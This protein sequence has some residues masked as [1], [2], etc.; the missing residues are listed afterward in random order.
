MC[1]NTSQTFL[2]TWLNTIV[3][4]SVDANRIFPKIDHSAIDARI[5]LEQSILR[6][7]GAPNNDWILKPRTV[8]C[9][10]FLC[11]AFPQC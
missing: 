8:Y 11:D 3:T 6:K 1:P 5:I 9:A 10:K 7:K 4:S 2:A